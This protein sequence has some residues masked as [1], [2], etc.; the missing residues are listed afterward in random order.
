MPA[1]IA[2]TAAGAAVF[3]GAKLYDR[4]NRQKSATIIQLLQ[5][6]SAAAQSPSAPF[7]AVIRQKGGHWQKSLV[8][9]LSELGEEY[10]HFVKTRVDPLFGAAR[11]AQL[12]ELT[13]DSGKL[14]ITPYERFIN[15]NLGI[16]GVITVAAVTTVQLNPLIQ[17]IAT[18]PLAFYLVKGIYKL[19]YDSLIVQRRI[20]LYVLSAVNVTAMWLGGYYI[21]GGLIFVLIYS[22]MKLSFITEDRSHKRLAD[23]FGQQPRTV[24]VFSNGV[25]IEIPFEQLQAGDVLVVSAGQMIAADGVIVQG[26]ASIDQHR[27]TGESQ[28]AEKGVGDEVQP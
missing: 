15:R 27:L 17:A 18:V 2:I 19:A 7:L 14:E 12:Q 1:L 28:P 26:Y 11:E 22:G 6:H 20:T 25:E 10:Q 9:S 24:W 16:A 3:G 8:A 21:V 23:I 13:A 4:R 5:E